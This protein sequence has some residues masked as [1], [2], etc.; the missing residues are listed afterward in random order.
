M[1]P[2]YP[3]SKIRYMVSGQKDSK[4]S[5]QKDRTTD[6]PPPS[7]MR[8]CLFA[9]ATTL[10]L[11]I[12]IPLV[13]AEIGLRLFWK[14]YYVKETAGRFERSATYGWENKP[15][16]VGIHGAP[17]FKVTVTH[18]SQGYRGKEVSPDRITGA[19]RVAFLGDSMTYGHGVEDDETFVALL[20]GEIET[21][22]LA[23]GGYSTAQEYTT[24]VEK[25]FGLQPDLVVL[26][27]FWNDLYWEDLD[28]PGPRMVVQD[29]NLVRKVADEKRMSEERILQ[30]PSPS[31]ELW[32]SLYLYR[33][34]SDNLK[35][36]KSAFK[37]S[38]EGDF[39]E[40]SEERERETWE[41]TEAL[42]VAMASECESR[43]VR[44]LAVLI[45][46]QVEVERGARVVGLPRQFSGLRDRLT[47]VAD[48][49]TIPFY[50]P[51]ECLKDSYEKE[52]T[53]YYYRMNRHLT[54]AGNRAMAD[55][56]GPVI[57]ESLGKKPGTVNKDNC[58]L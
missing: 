21:L 48:R 27:M 29:G 43:G 38:F 23:V 24:L 18:N 49:H 42:L 7:K 8:S 12:L 56:I 17:E 44:F 46:D 6:L 57:L 54:V 2:G 10:V 13:V 31:K 36:L 22:N 20:D 41:I 37:D 33:L 16:F 25:A 32:S 55:C 9:A 52:G 5:P 30:P 53:P 14:G 11:G 15:G 19:S 28:S 39:E 51:L 3:L 47:E 26:C 40:S 4:D 58:P 34:V 45:P 50:S 35:I 1:T